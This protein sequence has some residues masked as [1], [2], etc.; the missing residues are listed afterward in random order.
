M[1]KYIAI[2]A[3]ALF[4]F[5]IAGPGLA[6]QAGPEKAPIATGE[7]APAGPI[8]GQKSDASKKAQQMTPDKKKASEAPP[9]A[10]GEAKPAGDIKGKKSEKSKKRQ[11]MTT[12]KEKA[13]KTQ[14]APKQAGD[15]AQP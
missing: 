1:K 15:A 14:K 9:V 2:M 12:E 7:A 10:Q 8:K 13:D 5:G 3:A 4:V 11:Q 6:Q